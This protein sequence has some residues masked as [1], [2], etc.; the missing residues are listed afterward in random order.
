MKSKVAYNELHEIP[1]RHGITDGKNVPGIKK[2]HYFSIARNDSH[3]V[4]TVV[5]KDSKE[6]HYDGYTPI[7]N[8]VKIVDNKGQGGIDDKVEE[9]IIKAHE[10]FP[11][12]K[13]K[14]H[15]TLIAEDKYRSNLK[16]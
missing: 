10:N 13:H 11:Y 12:V 15:P 2:G 6:I 3:G 7:S 1:L 9:R 8:L 4:V 5:D 16:Y 14:D